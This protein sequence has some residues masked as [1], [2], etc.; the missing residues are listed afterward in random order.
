MRLTNLL[1]LFLLIISGIHVAHASQLDV[2]IDDPVYEYLDRLATRGLLPYYLNDIKPLTRDEIARQLVRLNEQRDALSRVD[3]QLLDEYRADYRFELTDKRYYK[4]GKGKDTWFWFSGAGSLKNGFREDILSYTPNREKPR[5]MVYESGKEMVWL[6]WLE[7]VRF[8]SKNDLGRIFFQHSLRL[9]TQLGPHFS[10][11]TDGNLYSYTMHHGFT[12][13]VPEYKGGFFSYRKES[14]AVQYFSWDYANA[15]IQYSSLLGD[16][17][18]GIQPLI[19]GN[20]THSL[21][22]SDNVNQFP[23]VSWSKSIGKSRFSFFHGKI[24]PAEPTRNNPNTGSKIYA[25]K[26]LVGHRWEIS[27]SKKLHGTFSEMLVYGDRNPELVYLIPPVF[28]WPIQHSLTQKNQDN[29]LWFFEGEYFPAPNLKLYGTF[30]LDELRFSEMFKNWT[31]NRW[32]VQG[33]FQFTPPL[34]TV[35]T[36]FIFEFTAVRPW[37]YTHRVPLFGT[38]SHGGQ[39][40]GFYAG[41]NSQLVYAENRWWLSRRQFLSLS[42]QQLKHG[43]NP[44][45]P[46]DPDYYP[47]G[48]DVNE[49]YLDRNPAFDQNTRWL[50]GDIITTKDISLNWRYQLSNVLFLDAGY[51][52]RTQQADHHNFFRLQIMMD[53]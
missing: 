15:Y 25:P 34:Q 12:E 30:L 51:T 40:L 31:G 21:I 27:F 48:S 11:Y 36:D 44:L 43:V 5:L 33:G 39:S 20:G 9:S 53:Y 4:L 32:A 26:Y 19:W 46:S 18:A 38:Y 24:Q 1:L 49:S 35:S 6:D 29:I 28:L 16:M 17:K 10:A 7:K 47:I 45:D 22:L 41:P 37:T 8:E 13:P 2:P 14:E 52:Y 42:F 23:F 3:R 50:M